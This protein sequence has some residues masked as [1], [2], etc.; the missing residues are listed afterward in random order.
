MKWI[1][2][3]DTVIA[4]AIV[5]LVLIAR[6]PVAVFA[7]GNCGNVACGS[8]F[9]GSFHD[10]VNGP[11]A[12]HDGT[13]NL[14]GTNT[15]VG[16]CTLC[17][18]PH[19]ALQTALL[20]NHHLSN[21][22]QFTWEA[23]AVTMAGTPYAT[24]ANNWA[25]PTS[26]CLSCHDG[27]VS[28]ST[29]NWYQ[30]QTPVPGTAACQLDNSNGLYDLD[31]PSYIIVGIGG[32]MMSTHPVAMPYPCGGNPSTYNGVTTGSA[33]V[34]SEW[35]ASPA[36]PIQLYQNSNGGVSRSPASGCTSGSAGIECTS[37]HDVHNKQAQDIDLVRGMVSGGGS[38]YICNECHNK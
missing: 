19:K 9:N 26:K 29:I 6:T 23:N 4:V 20:W 13:V 34:S 27:S 37:C 21:N 11:G 2:W 14:N 28:A 35:V 10:F 12:A 17:H 5:A 15:T 7:N 32:N 25:G 31:C 38:T 33:I 1:R 18:T 36:S 3:V 8:G 16:Q 22:T 24:I 30:G